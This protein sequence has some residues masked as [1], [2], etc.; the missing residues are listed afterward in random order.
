MAKLCVIGAATTTIT[1]T[2]IHGS[3][4]TTATRTITTAGSCRRRRRSSS[5]TADVGMIIGNHHQPQLL[6]GLCSRF[7]V[8]WFFL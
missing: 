8:D 6:K 5:T 4:V 7:V 2:G 3:F 1:A